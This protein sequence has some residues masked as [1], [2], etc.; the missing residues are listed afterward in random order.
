MKSESYPISI[1][2]ISVSLATLL[3]VAGCGGSNP[4]PVPRYQPG[5][6]DKS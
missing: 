4:N 2:M 6:E 3:F 5:D 1:K